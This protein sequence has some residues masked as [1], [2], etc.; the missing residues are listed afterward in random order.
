MMCI[1]HQYKQIMKNQGMAE[2]EVTNCCGSLFAHPGWPDNDLCS[3]CLEHSEPEN[4][5]KLMD[6]DPIYNKVGRCEL[7]HSNPCTCLEKI[8]ASV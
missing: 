1:A 4:K 5:E 7:C 6:M 2:I 8:N 3:E